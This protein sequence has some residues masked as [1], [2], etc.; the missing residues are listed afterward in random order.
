MKSLS[1]DLPHSTVNS[2]MSFLYMGSEL[3]GGVSGD[4]RY[5]CPIEEHNI[6]TRRHLCST[7]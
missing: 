5:D 7:W 3:A 1:D 4:H 2:T 6:N